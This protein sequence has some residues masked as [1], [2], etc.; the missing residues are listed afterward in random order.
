[1]QLASR[2]VRTHRPRRFVATPLN[3]ASVFT[4]WSLSV[5]AL[6]SRAC[7]DTLKGQ[8]TVF[9]NC[10]RTNWGDDE[11]GVQFYAE[12][13]TATV[14]LLHFRHLCWLVPLAS[15]ERSRCE[16]AHP[17]RL[18]LYSTRPLRAAKD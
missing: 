17:V 5:A 13:L 6:A 1:M 8:A 15:S 9:S 16:A 18:K 12:L 4:V 11:V 3:P 7:A 10:F 14:A 2:M